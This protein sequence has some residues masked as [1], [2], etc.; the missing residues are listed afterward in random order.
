VNYIV[1]VC[2]AYS[3]QDLLES[4]SRVV[5]GEGGVWTFLREELPEIPASHHSNANTMNLFV[6]K[7]CAMCGYVVQRIRKI[8]Y[9]VFL[10]GLYGTHHF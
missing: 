8:I 6:S 7:F 4:V 10:L 2:V 5:L 1:V 3:S 9:E